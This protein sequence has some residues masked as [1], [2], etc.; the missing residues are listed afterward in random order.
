MAEHLRSLSILV[1]DAVGLA[2]PRILGRYIVRD[3]RPASARRGRAD[4]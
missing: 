2:V 1:Q 3:G 4:D